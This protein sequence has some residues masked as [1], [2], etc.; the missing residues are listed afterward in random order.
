MQA[1]TDSAKG[2]VDLIESRL[3]LNVENAINLRQM[4]VKP[5]REYEQWL[6][7]QQTP[8]GVTE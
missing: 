8:A 3:M 1:Q 2:G 6:L 7:D 5:P 4:P